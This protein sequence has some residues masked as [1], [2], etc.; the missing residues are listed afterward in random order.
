MAYPTRNSDP[1]GSP[2]QQ[3]RESVADY[4]ERTKQA[5]QDNEQADSRDTDGQYDQV[6]VGP[7]VDRKHPHTDAEDRK[8][9]DHPH[10]DLNRHAD[11]EY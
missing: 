8:V 1:E 6:T 7:H 11:K 9:G 10:K 2:N 3:E 5:D 4:M